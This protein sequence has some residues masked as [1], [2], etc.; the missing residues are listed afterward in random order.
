MFENNRRQVFELIK[1]WMEK[2]APP[3]TSTARA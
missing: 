1:G 2:V 3:T